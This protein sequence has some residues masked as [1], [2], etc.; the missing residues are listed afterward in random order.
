MSM[1][2]L[3]CNVYLGTLSRTSFHTGIAALSAYISREGHRVSLVSANRREEMMPA[4]D[5]AAALSPDIVAF[6]VSTSEWPNVREMAGEIKRRMPDVPVVC[7]GYHVTLKP[8]EVAACPDVDILCLGEGEEAFAEM[9]H[10]LEGGKS[11]RDVR[12]LWVREK[13]WFRTSLHKNPLR[14]LPRD[15]DE[16]PFW[17]RELFMRDAGMTVEDFCALGGM[18]VGAGRGC[19]YSCTFCNNSTYIREFSGLGKYVRKRSPEN[20]IAEMKMLASGG[21]GEKFELWDELFAT[22]REWVE[23][24]CGRYR[25]EIGS[26]YAVLLRVDEA[27]DWLLEM[28]YESGCRLLLIG[29]EVGNE[30]FRR[31]VLKKRFSNSD[32]LRVFHKCREMGMD[33]FAFFMFG[34]PGEDMDMIEESVDFARKL[35]PTYFAPQIFYPLVGTEL[36]DM[37]LEQGMLPEEFV[38]D[39]AGMKWREDQAVQPLPGVE[40]Y[41]PLV[42]GA[43]FSLREMTEINNRMMALAQE[44][45]SS[46][47]KHF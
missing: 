39:P 36:Y 30:E 35:A 13:G 7:G 37:A 16:L 20:I 12:N 27:K 29:V 47:P 1:H 26:P 17:D 23:E 3:F 24:F 33:T 9:L 40:Y 32:A 2:V 44:M 5:R 38:K 10:N 31:K 8:D 45:N 46:S 11:C 4:V 34:L 22:R 18:P 19:P 6:S 21:M 25:E 28:L 41:V 43:R 42:N 15:L 14:P